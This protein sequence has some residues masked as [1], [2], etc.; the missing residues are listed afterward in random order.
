M[1]ILLLT[2]FISFTAFSQKMSEIKLQTQNYPG[3]LTADELAKAIKQDFNSKEA[4]A[5]ALYCWLTQHIRYDLEAFYNPKRKSKISFQYRTL[6]EKNRKIKAFKDNIVRKTLSSRKAVCEGYAQTFSSICNILNIENEVING[7][8][9]SSISDIGK[10]LQNP[11]HSWN[12]IKLNGN[13]FYIDTTWGAGYEFNGR[14]VRKFNSYYY[15]IPKHSY[16]KT[17][18]PEK[19]IW[20]LRVG[21]MDKKTFYDQPIYSHKFL[22][23]NVALFYSNSGFLKKRRDGIVTIELKKVL[24]N[25]FLIG[26]N[27]SN[28]AVKPNLMYKDGKTTITVVAP[29]KASAVYLL[30]DREVAIQ[31]RV[32][33]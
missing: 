12:A 20:R 11:N 26:F 19:S 17:H 13:W 1:R 6:E 22:K 32:Q 25:E 27:D 5:M 8:V 4:Q 31:F 14:W 24:N 9:R 33:G 28:M 7:Y 16:F 2:L 10:P 23:S 21:R 30:I 18:L 29:P 3:L 15:N